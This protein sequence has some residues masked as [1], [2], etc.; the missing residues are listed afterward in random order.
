MKYNTEEEQLK[1]CDLTNWY[2][3]NISGYKMAN[4]SII[5]NNSIV[6]HVEKRKHDCQLYFIGPL[7]KYYQMYMKYNCNYNLLSFEEL[8]LDINKFLEKILKLNAFE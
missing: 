4:I 6:L 8:L 5:S 3:F 2:I 7:Y 1:F